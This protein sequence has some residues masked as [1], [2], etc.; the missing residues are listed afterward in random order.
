M[1][2]FLIISLVS[3][4]GLAQTLTESHV[5]KLETL[6]EVRA[7]DLVH[8]NIG[9]P[10]N[11]QCS[12]QSGLKMQAWLQA[13]RRYNKD[14]DV[15]Y[16]NQFI[17][18]NGH[19]TTFLI[20]EKKSESLDPIIFSSRCQSHKKHNI[21][22]ATLFLKSKPE[23]K[24]IVFNTLKVKNKEY[25]IPYD[26][27]ILGF[28]D[29]KPVIIFDEDDVFYTATISK[30]LKFKVINLKENELNKFLVNKESSICKQKV[31]KDKYYSANECYKVYDLTKNKL[32]N[33]S[34]KWS[35]L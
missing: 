2:R 6:K 23:N 12:E 21:I 27:R 20:N 15:K 19:P 3:L 30:S 13:L 8:E 22:E 28:K 32:I 16:L 24:E 1:K 25:T 33:V 35:C 11:S 17:K 29:D 7:I 31:V 26:T 18:K 5:K 34:Q 10:E 9:C 4:S 14:Q